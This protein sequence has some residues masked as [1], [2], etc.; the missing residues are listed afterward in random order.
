MTSPFTPNQRTLILAGTGVAVLV[1][2][3]HLF[4]AFHPRWR[5][6]PFRFT[7]VALAVLF[8][9]C[10]AEGWAITCA[11]S[12]VEHHLLWLPSGAMI[13][14]GLVAIASRY[15]EWALKR[16]APPQPKTNFEFMSRW[17]DE[18]FVSAAKIYACVLAVACIGSLLNLYLCLFGPNCP[19]TW[20]F[21]ISCF[22]MGIG[23]LILSKQPPGVRF[24]EVCPSGL[25]GRDPKLNRLKSPLRGL[26][27]IAG[28]CW[29]VALIVMIA[30]ARLDGV[31]STDAPAFAER[32][33]YILTN[34]GKT[35]EVSRLRYVSVAAGGL[36]AWHFG[37]MF[38]ALL[39]MQGLLFCVGPQNN[40]PS[41]GGA[42]WL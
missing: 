18:T 4:K 24:L 35:I 22:L 19:W 12:F 36:A 27:V 6:N 21:S 5:S 32:D 10:A 28:I 31:P 42:P 33:H 16:G 1:A 2:I 17:S 20:L 29:T 11:M 26:I 38:G 30:S 25:A 14:L 8:L 37:A 40:R 3:Y 13:G 9:I 39:A 7:T 34:H 23:V 41:S 15:D